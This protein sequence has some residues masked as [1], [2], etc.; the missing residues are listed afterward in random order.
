M[1]ATDMTAAT[2]TMPALPYPLEIVNAG[3]DTYIVMSKGHHDPH[4]FM[5]KVR[6]EGYDWPLGFPEHRWI[7]AIPTRDPYRSCAY[8]FAEPHSRGSFP[9]TYA[10]EAYGND[11][12]EVLANAKDTP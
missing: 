11:R 7:R 6:E 12:Y 2:D 1:T 3:E 9:A 4:I 10:W 8:T 5:A